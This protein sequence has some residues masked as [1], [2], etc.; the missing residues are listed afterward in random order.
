MGRLL[1]EQRL[2]AC[3]NVHGA[4]RSIYRWN[5]AVTEETEALLVIKTTSAGYP[6][7]ERLLIEQHPYE[8]PEI[9]AVP[10]E[11]GYEPYLRWIKDGTS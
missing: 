4:V 2:A 8:L 3:V 1:V 9:I 11:T 10:I 5:D 6:E 7:V